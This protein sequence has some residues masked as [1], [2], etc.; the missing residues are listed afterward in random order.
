M[1]KKLRILMLS[2]VTMMIAL[3]LIVA[4]TFALFTAEHSV[5][6]HLQAGEM[7]LELWRT[8]LTKMHLKAAD[9]TVD[10]FL[11]TWED[12][13][14]V[15]FTQQQ[16]Q[17]IFGLVAGEV[18]VPGCIFDAEMELRATGDVAFTYW[19]EIVLDTEGQDVAK[20]AAFAEQLK[21]TVRVGNSVIA[22]TPAL[23]STGNIAIGSDNTPVG[24]AS[25]AANGAHQF[26]IEIEFLDTANNN[27]AQTGKV[28]FDLVVHATQTLDA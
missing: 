28:S 9:G 17:N 19:L 4:A 6:N 12:G 10:G 1:T 2:C 27:A 14:D 3:A 8:N 11:H 24:T 22:N 15:D 21:I 5:T 7:K 26:S 25:L 13:E 18:I 16:T 23:L 20:N